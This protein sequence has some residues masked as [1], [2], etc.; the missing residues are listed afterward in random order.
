MSRLKAILTYDDSWDEEAIRNA[1]EDNDQFPGIVSVEVS[2]TECGGCA[3]QSKGSSE[4]YNA[5]EA[6]HSLQQLKAKISA[7]R[8]VLM[9][10][11]PNGLTH[12]GWNKL[13]TEM[14]DAETSAV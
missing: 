1:F 7:W 8:K 12:N 2:S 5:E 14:A 6:H 10:V 9:A 13:L 11:G 4:Q 3:R